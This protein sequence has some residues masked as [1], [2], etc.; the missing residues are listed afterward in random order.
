MEDIPETQGNPVFFRWGFLSRQGGLEG[1]LLASEPKFIKTVRRSKKA[2]EIGEQNGQ[3]RAQLQKRCP[4]EPQESVEVK[5]RLCRQREGKMVGGEERVR[6][7][8]NSG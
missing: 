8:A 6:E 5:A 7:K 2:N 4:L 3:V 1:A